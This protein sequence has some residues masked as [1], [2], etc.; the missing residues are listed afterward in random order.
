M[1]PLPLPGH[2][3]S[4]PSGWGTL[5]HPSRSNSK[6]TSSRKPVWAPGT[7]EQ[8]RSTG[9][10]PS[11]ASLI[12]VILQLVIQTVDLVFSHSGADPCPCLLVHSA[13]DLCPTSLLMCQA[14]MGLGAGGAGAEVNEMLSPAFTMPGFRPGEDC[15]FVTTRGPHYCLGSWGGAQG[16]RGLTQRTETWAGPS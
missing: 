3:I 16:P 5:T 9:C 14:L 6:A 13:A 15:P 10:L 4:V 8:T 12:R 2:L 7:P 1:L 11:A